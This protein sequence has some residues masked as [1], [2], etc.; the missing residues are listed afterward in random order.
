MAPARAWSGLPRIP[1]HHVARAAAVPWR[2]GALF[3]AG[4]CRAMC[5][6][7]WACLYYYAVM[8]DLKAGGDASLLAAAGL[9]RNSTTATA[10]WRLLW[11][12]HW[13]SHHDAILAGTLSCHARRQL[14]GSCGWATSAASPCTTV[15]LLASPGCSCCFPLPVIHSCVSGHAFSLLLSAC[16]LHHALKT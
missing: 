12:S 2:T 5:W 4:R 14:F 11:K 6:H 15:P 7:A 9:V 10:C 3:A 8:E 1:T 16:L 13:L